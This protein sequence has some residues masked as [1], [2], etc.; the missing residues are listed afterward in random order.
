MAALSIGGRSTRYS[1]PG[2]RSQKGQK[3]QKGGRC[4]DAEP[5]SDLSG[6]SDTEAIL[7]TLGS[8]AWQGLEISSCLRRGSLRRP[9]FG[10]DGDGLGD[11]E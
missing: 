11:F 1:F 10:P 2:H 6:L 3:G 9:A 4:H 8:D 5:L 7:P